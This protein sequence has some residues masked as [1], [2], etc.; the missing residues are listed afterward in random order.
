MQEWKTSPSGS[1]PDFSLLGFLLGLIYAT[2]AGLIFLDAVDYYINF[3]L[4]ITGFFETFGA[5]WIYHIEE[6]IMS[7]GRGLELKGRPEIKD[8]QHIHHANGSCC[9]V[10]NIFNKRLNISFLYLDLGL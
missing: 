9:F 6:Q 8:V 7:L 5:G 3:V 1:W 10:L 4:L 2:D